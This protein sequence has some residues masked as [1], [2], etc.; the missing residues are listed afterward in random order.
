MLI[1]VFYLSLSENHKKKS[2]K[3][4]KNFNFNVQFA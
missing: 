4:I 2:E 3:F 1:D